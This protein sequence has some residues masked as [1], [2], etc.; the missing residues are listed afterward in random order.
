MDKGYDGEETH[1]DCR[2]RGVASVIPMREG[3]NPPKL[4]E[5]RR[6]RWVFAGADRKR[7]ATKWRVAL[8]GRGVQAC[9]HLEENNPAAPADPPAYRL[10]Q[11]T[12]PRPLSR[13]A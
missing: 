9:Q 6:G 10:L 5:C 12:V 7:N 2:R 3:S 4:P 1:R 11:A 8:P 13:R